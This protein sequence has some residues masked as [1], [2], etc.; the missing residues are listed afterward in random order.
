MFDTFLIPLAQSLPDLT[1]VYWICLI[2]GGGLVMMSVMSATGSDADIDIDADV[3]ADV[4]VE[5]P[6]DIE[7]AADAHAAGATSLTTWFSIRFLVFF[8]AMFGVVGVTLHYASGLEEGVTF[9]LSLLSGLIAGQ[10]VHQLFRKL[11]QTSGNSA[12]SVKDYLNKTGRVTATIH[13]SQ[14]GE[15]AVKVRGGGRYV[16]A[17]SKHTDARFNVGDEVAVVEY[18]GGVAVVVSRE[19][20]EFLREDNSDKKGGPI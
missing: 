17:T 5:T 8:M 15:I 20:Y 7:A 2:V 16:P 10:G 14:K 9:V 13:P 11:R 12:V 3:S 4:D 6:G 1:T 18:T 19:E